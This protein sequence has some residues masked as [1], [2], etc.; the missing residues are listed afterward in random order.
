MNKLKN[1][2]IACN[3]LGSSCKQ[4]VLNAYVLRE[5]KRGVWLK[6]CNNRYLF[7]RDK[8]LAIKADLTIIKGSL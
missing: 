7:I 4:K 3:Q 1:R 6:S 8:N 2:V 5:S